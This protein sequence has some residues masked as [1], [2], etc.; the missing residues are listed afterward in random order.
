MG[1]EK[2][3]GDNRGLS[4]ARGIAFLLRLRGIASKVL[5][6]RGAPL[7]PRVYDTARLHRS[8]KARACRTAM[9][10]DQKEF[11]RKQWLILIA[12]KLS[13]LQPR[14]PRTG[15]GQSGLAMEGFERSRKGGW[16]GLVISARFPDNNRIGDRL[17][18]RTS[19]E[20]GPRCP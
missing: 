17:V 5:P 11:S 20:P 19:F 2:G 7:V 12:R 13:G 6:L 9:E 15:P 10:K 18:P 14:S 3:V 4:T 16:K 8:G 1:E